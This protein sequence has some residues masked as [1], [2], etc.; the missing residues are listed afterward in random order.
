M[1]V[2]DITFFFPDSFVAEY[3]LFFIGEKLPYD[4]NTIDLKG[5]LF[6]KCLLICN[7]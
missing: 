4:F 5:P 6:P 2:L 3:D 7:S 1:L